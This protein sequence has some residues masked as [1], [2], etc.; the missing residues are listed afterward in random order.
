MVVVTSGTVEVVLESRRIFVV[1]VATCVGLN[2]VEFCT[3]P[4]ETKGNISKIRGLVATRFFNSR[5]PAVKFPAFTLAFA[6][7]LDKSDSSRNWHLHLF[8]FTNLAT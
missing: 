3:V 5:T 8:F 4:H 7:K 2:L 6:E 1:D